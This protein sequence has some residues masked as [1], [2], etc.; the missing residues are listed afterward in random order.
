MALAPS[1]SAL[2]V[3]HRADQPAAPGPG[4]LSAGRTGRGGRRRPGPVEWDYGTYE[5][6]TTAEIRRRAR[7]GP[8]RRRCPG[9]GDGRRM[10]AA[11][12]TGSSHGSGPSPAMWPA[13]PTAT[14]CGSW[15]PGGSGS[16][17]RPAV[18]WRCARP[19]SASWA[20][21]ASSRSWP[22]NRLRST[23]EPAPASRHGRRRG[24]CGKVSR[25]SGGGRDLALG[26]GHHVGQIERVEVG[27][28]VLAQVGPDGEQHALSLVVAGPVLVGEPEVTGH[29]GPVD[30]GDDLGQGDLL[31]WPG[32]HVAAAD[33]PLGTDQAGALQGQ[34]DLLE[35][36]L[37]QAGALGD[38]PDRGG[39]LPVRVEGQRQQRPAGIVT[40]SRYLHVPMLLPAAG[41][42]LARSGDGSALGPWSGDGPGRGVVV[43]RSGT[44]SRLPPIGQRPP[45]LPPPGPRPWPTRRPPA[46]LRPRRRPPR[47]RRRSPRPPALWAHEVESAGLAPVAGH[48]EGAVVD[49]AVGA[50]ALGQAPSP[51]P[52]L[53]GG[54]VARAGHHV[55]QPGEGPESLAPEQ[56]GSR[57]GHPRQERPATPGGTCRPS[58]PGARCRPWRCDPRWPARS[59]G[60]AS[61]RCAPGWR[62]SNPGASILRVPG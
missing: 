26:P 36:G 6:L 39:A 15:P 20:G 37:G 44:S 5:G 52:L 22:W 54:L 57:P 51:C 9:R 16:R 2:S 34:Q 1:L 13:W 48:H 53:A 3:R 7:V 43:R 29:D 25:R 59:G 30:R 49:P 4:D 28:H 33:P 19:P 31:G 40:S 46:D 21:T 58:W 27:A 8:L 47:R 62:T 18:P 35:V 23:P 12:S 61:R 24:G 38:V 42:P 56:S 45:S 50:E 32:Q 17:P 55:G 10:W 14:C 41:R 60:T 11:G